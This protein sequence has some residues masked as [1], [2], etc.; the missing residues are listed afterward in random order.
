MWTLLSGDVVA[1]GGGAVEPVLGHP[2]GV[3]VVQP[4]AR[5]LIVEQDLKGRVFGDP[6]LA[7]NLA[8]AA[9]RRGVMEQIAINRAQN[10]IPEG[11]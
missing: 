5:D 4:A 1:R 2:Q 6:D 9:A 11:K 7:R 8:E 10:V 3:V